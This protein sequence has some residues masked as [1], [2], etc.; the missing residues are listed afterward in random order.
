MPNS[1]S[2][3]KK[4]TSL[5]TGIALVLLG[6]IMFGVYFGYNYFTGNLK[7]TPLASVE[8]LFPRQQDDLEIRAEIAKKALANR[9]LSDPYNKLVIREVTLFDIN[10]YPVKWQTKFFN[11]AQVEN[12]LISGP[13]SDPDSDGLTNRQEFLVAS[14]P[15]KAYTLCG[16]KKTEDEKCSRN[17]K[18]NI[19][20]K[21]SPLTGFGFDVSQK[22]KIN[23]TEAIVIDNFKESFDIA[24][25]EGFD[26]PEIYQLSA[27]IDLT[28]QL[29]KIE[30]TILPDEAIN[31]GRY[32]EARLKTLESY[33]KLDEFT[34]FSKIYKTSDPKEVGKLKDIFTKMITDLKALV[35]AASQKRLQQATILTF[36]KNLEVVNL[37]IDYLTKP[38]LQ[39]GESEESKAKSKK[40]YLELM[41]S[42]RLLSQVS[43]ET[44][45]IQAQ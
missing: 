16:S 7:N 40:T 20:A 21:I 18:E 32:L 24:S 29:N 1:Q 14:N 42:Y 10:A 28:D 5:R 30:V 9:L 22:I 2:T 36:Q 13:D 37:R 31:I 15:L 27:G 34:G 4:G 19:D 38:E 39:L 26:F 8:S 35:P 3:P 6:G 43:G 25:G 33:G 17:D 12:K 44:N 41:A 23:S 45:Q 11:A